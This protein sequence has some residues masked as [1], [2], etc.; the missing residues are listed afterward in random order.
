MLIMLIWRICH[1]RNE[2]T[3]GKEVSPV[4]ATVEYLDSY[5]KSISIAGRSS[6]EEIIKG[7]MPL[8]AVHVPCRGDKPP[9]ASW[10]APC[11]GRL[12]LSVDGSFL[13]DDGSAAIGMVLRNE[14]GEVLMAAYRF[15]FY[16]NDPLEA[17][18]HVIIQ[19]LAL[20]IQHSHLPVVVQ[21]DSSE[22]LSCLNNGALL[23][24]AYG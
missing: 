23:R 13:K 9:E 4:P 14:K 16:C 1:L 6:T 10:P 21:T 22:A 2:L 3:H 11:Q 7:K 19:G 17:E 12:A 15:I 20:A 18:L 8:S 5:Y 24:S